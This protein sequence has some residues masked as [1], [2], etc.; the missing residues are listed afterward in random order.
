MKLQFACLRCVS[1]YRSPKTGGCLS[2]RKPIL[3]GTSLLELHL[4]E[5]KAGIKDWVY[6]EMILR[7]LS[8]SLKEWVKV[9]KT[10]VS[11]FKSIVRSRLSVLW[12]LPSNRWRGSLSGVT[13]NI[14]RNIFVHSWLCK[15]IEYRAISSINGCPFPPRDWGSVLACLVL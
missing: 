4:S 11:L 15:R 3:F 14:S 1:R 12:Y 13:L 9:G 7:F 2:G 10:G 6:G 8:L 5:S